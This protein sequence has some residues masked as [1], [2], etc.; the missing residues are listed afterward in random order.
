MIFWFRRC[1]EQSR[2]PSGQAVPCPSQ[3]SWTSM[4]RAPVTSRSR[5][6]TPLPKARSASS[7]VRSKTAA[8][9]SSPVTT[10]MPRPP[11][12]AAA[13]SMSG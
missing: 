6:T 10:R 2:T 8:S 5:K 3:M 4:W 13:L 9:S 11:P 7:R 12:P 1:M